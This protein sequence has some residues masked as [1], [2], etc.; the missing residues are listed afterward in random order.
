MADRERRRGSRD[1][2][3]QRKPPP[4]DDGHAGGNPASQPA[5]P[6]QAAPSEKQIGDGL[7]A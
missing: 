1:N 3:E 6:T 5:V 2:R 4:E 7:L